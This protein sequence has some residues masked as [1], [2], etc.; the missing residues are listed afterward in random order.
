MHLGLKDKADK[1]L[2]QERKKKVCYLCSLCNRSRLSEELGF[3]NAID[4]LLR[5]ECHSH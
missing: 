1:L 5:E 4:S 3:I 2:Y